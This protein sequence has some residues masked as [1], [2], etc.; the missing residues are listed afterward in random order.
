MK[1]TVIPAP[2]GW[3][4]IEEPAPP[5]GLTRWIVL[6]WEFKTEA[7]GGMFI[8]KVICTQEEARFGESFVVQ[9]D[10]DSKNIKL[11]YLG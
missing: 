4:L 2:P 5:D 9:W 3:I 6:T 7:G 1:G 10:L 11:E 8:Q